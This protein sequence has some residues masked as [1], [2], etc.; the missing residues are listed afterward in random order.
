MVRAARENHIRLMRHC[1]GLDYKSPKRG[2]YEAY[3]N[4]YACGA[5][6][7]EWEYLVSIGYAKLYVEE[8]EGWIPPKQYIYSLTQDGMDFMGVVTGSKITMRD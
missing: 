5:Q 7:S 8:K 1:I 3:R 2:K 6:N 4:Y